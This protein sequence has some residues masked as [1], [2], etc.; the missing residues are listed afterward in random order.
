M[1][2]KLA[3]RSLLSIV[4]RLFGL[5]LR[6]AHKTRHPRVK[7]S[8]WPLDQQLAGYGFA[9]HL[10]GGIKR[11]IMVKYSQIKTAGYDPRDVVRS[12]YASPLRRTDLSLRIVGGQRMEDGAGKR[13]NEKYLGSRKRRIKFSGIGSYWFSSVWILDYYRGFV[14]LSTN[15]ARSS[16]QRSC[17]AENFFFENG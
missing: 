3:T 16:F 4:T 12:G 14:Q 7:L 1:T 8:P 13:A 5:T 6:H 15:N 2:S 11:G 10:G 9:Q 17:S